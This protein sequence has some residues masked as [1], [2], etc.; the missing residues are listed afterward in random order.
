V[1]CSIDNTTHTPVLGSHAQVHT[2]T[3]F[4]IQRSWVIIF[5]SL[6]RDFLA[7]QTGS[8]SYWVSGC[9]HLVR[10]WCCEKAMGLWKNSAVSDINHHNIELAHLKKE[11]KTFGN[12]AAF[13]FGTFTT[14]FCATSGLVGHENT[15]RWM[16]HCK[17]YCF[18]DLERLFLYYHILDVRTIPIYRIY[19]LWYIIP[20]QFIYIYMYV[21]QSHFFYITL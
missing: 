15:W 10:L 11:R 13:W 12:F 14:L 21:Y 9:E 2:P 4:L 19:W 5:M 3:V 18:W 1:P 8:H 16:V 7:S 20:I 6:L 17:L